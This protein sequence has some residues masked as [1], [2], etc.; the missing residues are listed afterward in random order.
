[1]APSSGVIKLSDD[2]MFFTGKTVIMDHGLG[3]I[4]IFAHLEEISV[5]VGDKVT[6]GEKIGTVG[7]TGRASGPH[8]HWGIY[9]N[10][11]SV[12]P[13]SVLYYELN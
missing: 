8:L 5:S 11:T 1:M 12:D 9:L 6:Q 10:E 7:M 13:M 2:D 4:S 3:L